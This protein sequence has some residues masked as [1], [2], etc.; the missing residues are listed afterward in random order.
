MDTSTWA[1]AFHS[2]RYDLSRVDEAKEDPRVLR[3]FGYFGRLSALSQRTIN[4]SAEIAGALSVSA[5]Y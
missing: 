4:E 2:D 5:P 3:S 1:D